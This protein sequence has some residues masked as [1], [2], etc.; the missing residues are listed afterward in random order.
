[1]KSISRILCT[2]ACALLSGTVLNAQPAGWEWK[3]I[4][5][6]GEWGSASLQLF[7][8][9]QTISA[10]RY[11]AAESFTELVSDPGKDRKRGSATP[12]GFGKRYGA[13]AVIN[14]SY[15]DMKT[16]RPTTFIRD[17]WENEGTPAWERGWR[18][19]GMI[20]LDGRKVKVIPYTDS[21]S[22]NMACRTCREMMETG[23]V[24][25]RG[26]RTVEGWASGH[27]FFSH[28]HPRSIL[29]IGGGHVYFI[30]ID[31]RHPGHADGVTIPEAAAIAE[32][33]SLTDA[34]NLDGGGSSALW[35][36]GIGVISHPSDNK[37][38][39]RRGERRVPN[40]VILR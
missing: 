30:V 29:G 14:G 39:D 4:K 13:R 25:I 24:L 35:V 6:G 27:G 1:M 19:D 12:S 8:S 31:G 28:R 9:D 38:F 33:F 11:P 10:V 40:A 5:G 34:V 20:A 26:G 17:G 3:G 36:K 32:M 21:I 15:F 37:R 2:A 18:T 23:P 22:C 16:L 7:G